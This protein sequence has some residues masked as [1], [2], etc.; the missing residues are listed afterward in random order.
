MERVKHLEQMI[1]L[2]IIATPWSIELLQ[3]QWMSLGLGGTICA[4]RVL[5]HLSCFIVM[6]WSAHK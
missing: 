2:L 3:Q 4:H 6:N 1:N 5:Y